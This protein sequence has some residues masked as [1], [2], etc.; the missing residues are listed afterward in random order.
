MTS[1]AENKVDGEAVAG[2]LDTMLARELDRES[3][4]GAAHR[5]EPLAH[6]HQHLV[7]LGL[8]VV[9]LEDEFG[10]LDLSLSAIAEVF[11]VVGR[12]PRARRHSA[13]VRAAASRRA[14]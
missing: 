3:L 14:R 1:V 12:R 11:A 5:N 7:E 8:P 2:A 9:A 13:W 6:L 10:G 4:L